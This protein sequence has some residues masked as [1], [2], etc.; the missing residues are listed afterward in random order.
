MTKINGSLPEKF[1]AGMPQSPLFTQ[2]AALMRAAGAAKMLTEQAVA[3]T[4]AKEVTPEISEKMTQLLI[5]LQNQLAMID[6]EH[7]SE[8]VEGAAAACQMALPEVDIICSGFVVGMPQKSKNPEK[9]LFIKG[10][11]AVNKGAV[12]FLDKDRAEQLVKAINN[13]LDVLYPGRLV[14]TETPKLLLTQ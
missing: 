9:L 2:I 6:F 3:N 13:C 1:G 7:G 12:I 10:G 5:N 14:G 8:I 11:I 4:E